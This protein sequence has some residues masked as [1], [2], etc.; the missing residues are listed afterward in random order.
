MTYQKGESFVGIHAGFFLN[1]KKRN[2]TK[3]YKE[4][5]IYLLKT[6]RRKIK[7]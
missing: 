7:K 1:T 4:F 3:N 6:V 2:E 5:F